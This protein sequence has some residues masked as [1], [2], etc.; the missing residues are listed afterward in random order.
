M[1]AAF[2]QSCKIKVGGGLKC[3]EKQKKSNN[4]IVRV[5]RYYQIKELWSLDEVLFSG[6]RTLI[7]G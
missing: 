6:Q 3:Q 1:A 5:T 7:F 4:R 2:A